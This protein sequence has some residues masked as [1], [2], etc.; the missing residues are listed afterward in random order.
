V[1]KNSRLDS[2]AFVGLGYVGL[3]T[4]LCFASRG[5]DVLGV[6]VD[7]G[8]VDLI[9]SGRSPI[10]EAGIS[11]LLRQALRTKKFNVTDDFSKL[12]VSKVIFLTVGTPSREDGSVETGFIVAA[13]REV[14]RQLSRSGDYHVIVVKSTVPPGT[15]LGQV[16]PILEGESGVKVGR[17]IGI[18]SNPEFLH[19]GSAIRET[20]HPDAVVI[21]GADRKSTDALLDLYDRFYGR[22]PPTI[23]TTPSNAEMMK[24]AINAGRASQL[25]FVNTVANLCSRIPG[26]DYDEVRKGLSAVAKMD[27]RYLAAGM[28][29]GGSCLPKDLRALSSTLKS[30]GVDN[31]VL[32]AALKV[33]EGQ[34]PEAIGMAERLCGSLGGKRVAVLGLAFKPET[35]DIRESVSISLVQSLVARGASVSVYDPVAMENAAKTLG[36]QVT[37]SRGIEDCLSGAECAFIATGWSE[38]KRLRPRDF[39]AWMASPVV[40]DGRRIFEP[41]QFVKAG[42]QF[43]II[44]TGSSVP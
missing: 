44:G 25:S 36:G 41:K 30:S 24:Y 17:K 37:Y 21:G 12:A 19:E 13:S 23:I 7:R 14:G 29:F 20:L 6:E 31:G 18:A 27:E 38:F 5:F 39:K 26:C 3:S 2:V 8:K 4:A 9:R 43:A 32:S 34:V 42:V 35:D 15:T 11:G 28:G 33:N 40:V 22:R 10:H 1:P 16:K